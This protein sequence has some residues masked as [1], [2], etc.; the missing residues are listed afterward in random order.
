M[1]VWEMHFRVHKRLGQLA[2]VTPWLLFYKLD[3]LRV[4]FYSILFRRK[5]IIVSVGTSRKMQWVFFTRT[6]A[7]A[8]RMNEAI[9]AARPTLMVITSDRIC[10]IVSYMA[11]PAITEPPGQLT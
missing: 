11:S 5:Q 7:P 1:W 4:P 2:F 10:C 9:D 8:A 3:T 6:F